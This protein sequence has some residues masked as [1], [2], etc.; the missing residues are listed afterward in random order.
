MVRFYRVQNLKNGEGMS[1]KEQVF[2]LN[3]YDLLILLARW[4]KLFIINFIVVAIIA[5]IITFMLPVWYISTTVILPPA[6]GGGGLPSFLSKD[7]AGVAANFGLEMPTENIYQ[8]ILSSRTLKER[9]IERFHLRDV[10][11]MKADTKPEDLLKV[12]DAYYDINTREDMAIEVSFMAKDT[13]L[14]ANVANACVAELDNYYREITGK[15]ARTNRIFIGRRLQQINDT[16]D[17][18][19]DSIA[20]FQK[21]HNA[22]SVSDQTSAMISAAAALKAEQI[23]SEIQLQLL[24][25]TMGENHPEVMILQRSSEEIERRYTGLLNG[26][27]G[28]LFIALNQLP[29]IAKTYAEIVRQ[30]KIQAA[31]LEF[32]YPQFENARIQEA[33][34]TSN[35]QILDYARVPQKKIKPA[36][37]LIVM[38]AGAASILVTMILILLIEYWHALPGKNQGDWTKI[39][40]LKLLLRRGRK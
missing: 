15:S 4:R 36:R 32:V 5:S 38:I 10:Y 35:V 14:A 13:L 23:S 21:T 19:Q 30:Q 11:K 12:F 18:L 1:E 40:E 2:S 25:S 9:V 6:G 8:S 31:L 37:R 33:R 29:D 17:M 28:E 7:L 39:Q 34:E 20:S 27:E 24:R 16:L 3:F 22:I 26:S